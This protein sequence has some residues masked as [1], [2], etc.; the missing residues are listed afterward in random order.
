MACGD[1]PIPPGYVWSDAIGWYWGG[2]GCGGHLCCCSG[3]HRITPD[4]A[5]KLRQAVID[6]SEFVCDIEPQ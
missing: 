5:R 6:S 3:Q 1:F 2:C 4:D